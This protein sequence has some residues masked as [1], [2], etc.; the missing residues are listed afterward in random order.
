MKISVFITIISVMLA[1]CSVHKSELARLTPDMPATY[2]VLPGRP[3]PPIGRWW[4]KFDDENL[5]TLM[6]EAFRH[7]PDI[8]QAY[9]RLKQMQAIID[10]TDSSRGLNLN[11]EASADR[12]R[13]G[14]V[15]GSANIFNTYSLSAAAGYELDLWKRLG[16]ETGAARLDALASEEDLKALYMSI[17]AQLA[18]LYYL[19]V[20]Q[21]AQIELSDRTITSFEDTLELVERRYRA[22][23]VPAADLYRSRQNLSSAKAAKL[24]YESNLAVTLNAISVLTGHFPDRETGGDASVLKDVPGFDAGLPSQLLERRPDIRASLLRLKA[25]D[26]RIGSAIANRFPSFSLTGNYGGSSDELKRVLDSP[27]IFWNIILQ[28]VQPVLDAGRRAAE[29]DRAEAVFRENLAAYHKALLNAFREV[30][31]ALAKISAS[32]KRIAMLD[33]TVS[34]SDSSLRLALERYKHGL[35]DYL[36][37][38]TEQI[39]NATARSSLLA[40]R[41]QLISDRIQLARALGGEWADNII[42]EYLTEEEER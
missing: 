1:G 17:S 37:V 27:N 35:T 39:S 15:S 22:G 25:S 9:E 36:P 8:A 41:R 20:E 42:N 23:L 38:L 21:R 16:S 40:A 12:S 13:Q 30:E 28:A 24:L 31:D 33:K 10:I 4:K 18:E 3:S 11:I 14:E 19:A 2:S 26:E 32:E 34:A 29:V 5:N 7:N 6:E